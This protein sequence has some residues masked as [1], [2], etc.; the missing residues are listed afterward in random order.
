MQTY[1]EET[2]ELDFSHPDIQNLIAGI[3]A[4]TDKE[5]VVELYYLVRDSIRYN[6]YS[7]L[8]GIDSLSASY[9]ADK[10]DAFCVPKSALMVAACRGLGIPARLGLANVRNH[11]SSP[12]L[13]ELLRT[14]LFVM[15]GYADIYLDNK[16]V[17]CTP[18]FNLELCEKFGVSP[19]A[20]DGENDSI[21]HPHTQTGQKH[22]EYV[23]D[24]GTFDG[25]PV[26]FILKGVAEAYPHLTSQSESELHNMIADKEFNPPS[27]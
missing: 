1:L 21:F 17:K 18:V 10:K 14:D 23:T 27:N 19:L 25:V 9:A 3:K 20:F 15:H 2:T 26:A 5:R 8:D 22:M 4:G 11:L 13:L 12:K 7:F 24:H 16:W 6:P